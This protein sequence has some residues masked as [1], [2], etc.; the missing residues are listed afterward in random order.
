MSHTLTIDG[1]SFLPVAEAASHFGYTKYYILLLVK[2]GKIDG[3]K[4]EKRWYVDMRSGVAYFKDAAHVREARKEQLRKER[5]AE[6][7]THARV[8]SSSHR[9]AALLHSLVIM[10]IGL[11]VGVTGYLGVSVQSASVHQNESAFFADVAR[12]LYT[13]ISGEGNN[14]EI[15][16]ASVDV[17][18]S[19]VT[20]A[21]T[22]VASSEVSVAE[23]TIEIPQGL[24]VAPA[25]TFT[26]TSVSAIRDSFSDP[27]TVTIDPSQPDTG[28]IVP[29]FKERDGET[30]R[31]LMVP[32]NESGG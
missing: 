14:I 27:V 5:Q 16:T 2:E 13:F 19:T 30:Y 26:A 1:V 11:S 23:A 15:G 10:V 3:R 9:K 31:F 7:E 25:T 28:I 20:S 29:H 4:I 24:I 6:L 32:I 17:T 22:H 18:E 12:V 21:V 8:R